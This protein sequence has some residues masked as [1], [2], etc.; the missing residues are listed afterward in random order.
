MS[1]YLTEDDDIITGTDLSD[2]FVDRGP[3]GGFDVLDGRGG[4]D[5]FDLG[6]GGAGTVD[7]GTGFD[8][9]V[10]DYTNLG[11]MVFSNVERLEVLGDSFNST[12]VQ[13]SEFS[14]ISTVYSTFSLSLSG[15]G[16]ELD[17]STRLG[18]QKMELFASGL[19]SPAQIT[20]SK[21]SD[22]FH[23]LSTGY[24][25]GSGGTDL[26]VLLRTPGVTSI[27]LGSMVI[28]NVEK[29]FSDA[30]IT[31][32]I[33]QMLDFSSIEALTLRLVGS[34]GTLNL[35]SALQGHVDAS[36]LTSGAVL[37]VGDGHYEGSLVGS[38]FND[39]LSGSIR[40]DTI[41]GGLGNDTL[42]G[43]AGHDTLLG[44]L[45]DEDGVAYDEGTDVL[46]GGDGIDSLY[47]GGNDILNG[48]N[49]SDT[50][51]LG[52]GG[53]G[54]VD[55]GAD[56]DGV[57][58][59]VTSLGN[60]TFKNVENL[61]SSHNLIGKLV[62]FNSFQSISILGTISLAGVGG[63]LDLSSRVGG[64]VKVNGSALTS[65]VVLSGGAAG[66]ILRA[67]N[68]HDT[69]EG[70]AGGDYL[71]GGTGSDRAVY[72]NAAAGV[73]ANLSTPAGNSGEAAGDTYNSIESVTGSAF[74]DTLTGNAGTNSIIGGAGNDTV[75]GLAG[76]DNLFGQDGNDVLNGGAGAD[77][78]SGGAGSD[79][80]TY[81][82]A[83]SGVIAALLS[84][85]T[86]TGEAA[87]DTYT[88]IENLTGSAFNDRLT[89]TNSLNSLIGGAGN[90]TLVG[91][92]GDDNLFGQDGNDTF[93]GGVG[94]DDFSGGNGTDTASYETA[95]AAVIA[96]LTT[97]ASNT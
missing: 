78:L 73:V 66:D 6:P 5:Q 56:V 52:L 57:V 68:Y 86:N 40:N 60:F 44:V 39:T 17:F 70:G 67:T 11:S 51:Y 63:T 95:A 89:G 75:I 85:A 47:G 35:T 71:S 58:V 42:S 38:N 87:G 2:R 76:S 10:A 64:A 96:S 55:G 23:G 1:Y 41:R 14:E 27:S 82:D 24:L 53:S 74:N 92:G 80:A 94:A 22:T 8:T 7:G 79:R 16:G 26:L 93:I 49:G 77:A 33:D 62:Q 45:F 83:A 61:S 3:M 12:I 19:T 9:V 46:N 15:A 32:S 84:P 50:L 69:L 36:G 37:T 25:D 54:A 31:A 28:K 65:A 72:V 97:P 34:G 48:G 59:N 21:G 20:G 88:S 4:D 43:G 29:L 30:A 81:E 18:F 91:L 13:L 90:D